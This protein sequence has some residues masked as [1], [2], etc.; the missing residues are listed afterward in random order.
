MRKLTVLFT[1]VLTVVILGGCFE[2]PYEPPTG[3]DANVAVYVLNSSATS[4]SVIDLEED[5]VYNDVATVGVWPNQIVYRNEKLYCVNSG[6]NNITIYD[7]ATWDSETPIALGEGHNPMKLAFYDDNTAYVSCSVSG[8]VLKLDMVNKTVDLEMPA[9]T[10]CTGIAI[11]NDKVYAANTGY[12]YGSPYL[13]GTVNV[14]DATNG[15][16]IT[17]IDVATNPQDIAIAG[18]GKLHVVATGDYGSTPGAVTVIDPA[19]DQVVDTYNIGS[20]PGSI[21]IDPVNNTAYCGVWGMGAIAY[22]TEDGS[23][24]YDSFA[25][26]GGSGIMFFDDGVW[27]SGWDADKVYKY[28]TQNTVIDSFAV[29]DSPSALAFRNDPQE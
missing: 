26:H 2:P 13:Q 22:D 18:D 5:S 28:S 21:A 16:S 17:V 4:L 15:D 20:T 9:G 14:Y 24:E 25:G 27:I 29:G 10:G 6:S 19:T 12:V 11:A 8:K 3:A 23:V 1:V 7:V